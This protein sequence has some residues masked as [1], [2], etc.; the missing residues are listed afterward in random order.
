MS[1]SENLKLAIKVSS[2]IAIGAGTVAFTATRP[3]PP[4]TPIESIEIDVDAVS[5]TSTTFE[6]TE[7]STTST[8]KTTTTTSTTI[9][10]STTST[11]TAATTTTETETVTE[12]V[13]EL[14]T[15]SE[16]TQ[17]E[18]DLAGALEEEQPV[19]NSSAGSLIQ[20][21][22]R[23]TYYAPGS[24][25]GYSSM[26]G[27]GRY[28]LDCN[29]GGDGYAKGSIASGYLYNLLGYSGNGGRTAVWLEISGYPDMSGVYYLDDCSG[30]DVIDFFYDLSCNCQFCYTGVVSVD[31]YY[32][33]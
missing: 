12:S 4:Q 5:E 11:T 23:G 16:E 33:N 21:G 8:A 15:E 22:M 25:N 6:V 24:W 2:V 13:T 27:S 3:E 29:Y 17:T 30:A 14:V 19:Y 31:V 18:F 1:I 28:L 10:T 9:T 26:G 7:L 20:G 32:V